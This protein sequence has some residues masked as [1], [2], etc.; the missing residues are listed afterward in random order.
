LTMKAA[1]TLT[2]GFWSERAVASTNPKTVS[3]FDQTKNDMSVSF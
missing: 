2:P 3:T 1:L